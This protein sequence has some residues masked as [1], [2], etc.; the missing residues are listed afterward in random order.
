M[1]KKTYFSPKGR[2]LHSQTAARPCGLHV[3][4]KPS[5]D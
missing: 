3:T 2:V 4:D 1:E 5:V